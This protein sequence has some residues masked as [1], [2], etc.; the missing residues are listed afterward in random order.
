[1]KINFYFLCMYT[2]INPANL[3]MMMAALVKE[4]M[5]PASARHV[6]SPTHFGQIL[7]SLIVL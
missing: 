5:I 1:M 2:L 3:K 7:T 4:I 6:I